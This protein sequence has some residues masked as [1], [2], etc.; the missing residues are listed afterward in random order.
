MDNMI[1]V[2]NGVQYELYQCASGDW[3]VTVSAYGC[4]DLSYNCG[5]K[6]NAYAFILFESRVEEDEE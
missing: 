5:S 2:V 4:E 1:Y 6:E 3:C